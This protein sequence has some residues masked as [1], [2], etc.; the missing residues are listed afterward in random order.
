MILIE[1]SLILIDSPL[2]SLRNSFR[3]LETWQDYYRAKHSLLHKVLES[4]RGIP[5]SL[6]VVYR[7]VAL[8][9]GLELWG[10]NFPGLF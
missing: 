2:I 8:S 3:W 10:A 6:A 5:I 7:E 1:F 9:A 4:K